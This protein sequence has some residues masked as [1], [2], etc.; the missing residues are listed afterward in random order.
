MTFSNTGI[1]R[2]HRIFVA[3]SAFMTKIGQFELTIFMAGAWIGWNF[4]NWYFE[5]AIM[6]YFDA[7]EYW[8]YYELNKKKK[9]REPMSCYARV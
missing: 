7:Y 9:L 2:K 4:G 6:P 1:G 8:Q 3:P 5:N